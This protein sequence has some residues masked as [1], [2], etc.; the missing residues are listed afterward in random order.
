MPLDGTFCSLAAG[1]TNVSL[2]FCTANERYR[3]HWNF[4]TCILCRW[5]RGWR[6]LPRPTRRG[7]INSRNKKQ[8][9]RAAAIN[10]SRLINS[11]GCLTLQSRDYAILHRKRPLMSAARW[12][13]VRPMVSAAQ[14]AGARFMHRTGMDRAKRKRSLALL[15][16]VGRSRDATAPLHYTAA[17][18]RHWGVCVLRSALSEFAPH[19]RIGE[20]W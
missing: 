11:H 8:V 18:C 3:R 9:S 17:K 16:C 1:M 12:P 14:W 13:A 2:I 15:H 19:A 4:S 5:R 6:Y 10:I 20:R 7:A